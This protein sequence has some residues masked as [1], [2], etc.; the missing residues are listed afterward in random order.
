MLGR[1]PM[2][3]GSLH[4]GEKK[5]EVDLG[6][7]GGARAVWKCL[8]EKVASEWGFEGGACGQVGWRDGERRFS[9]RQ[10]WQLSREARG[11][12]IAVCGV[13]LDSDLETRVWGG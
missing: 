5:S 6:R 13:W 9:R 3:V 1:R 10:R 7:G 8:A 2:L 11:Q 12:R 4:T